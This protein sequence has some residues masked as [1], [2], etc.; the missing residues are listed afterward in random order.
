MRLLHFEEIVEKQLGVDI[1]A[2]WCPESYGQRQNV[3]LSISLCQWA[4]ISE[5]RIHYVDEIISKIT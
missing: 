1:K 2:E 3:L 4:G 5:G